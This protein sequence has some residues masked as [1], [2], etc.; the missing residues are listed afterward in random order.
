M[1]KG[2]TMI[3]RSRRY[4]ATQK[5][6]QR[7]RQ[8][9]R[10]DTN[11]H[12]DGGNAGDSACCVFHVACFA[13]ILPGVFQIPSHATGSIAV[14]GPHRGAPSSQCSIPSGGTG[15]SVNTRSGSIAIVDQRVL[16]A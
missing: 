11:S 15:D 1:K 12:Q 3:H 14:A 4:K 6:H 5:F 13:I 10:R 8:T 16:R 2:R 9:R 7:E